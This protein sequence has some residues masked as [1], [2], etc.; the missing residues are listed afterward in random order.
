[1]NTTQ[2]RTALVLIDFI[3]RLNFPEGRAL[4]P[5]AIAAAR[6]TA[7][8]KRR[9]R[10]RGVPVIYA[11]DNFGKWRSQFSDLVAQ[12]RDSRCKGRQLVTLLAPEADDY[13]VLKPRHSAFFDTPLE[14]LLDELG[15]DT[16]VLTGLA[17][18]QCVMFT[19]HDAHIRKYRQWIPS[20]CV[21]SAL[22]REKAAALRHLEHVLRASTRPSTAADAVRYYFGKRS[23][24]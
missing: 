8:L 7:M 18:E 13:S 9:A 14:F 20:D 4:L 23:S 17:T 16:L 15:V 19:A 12:C 1:M 10:V 5:L 22:P 6:R 21:A 3:N 11:N 2:P 24:R